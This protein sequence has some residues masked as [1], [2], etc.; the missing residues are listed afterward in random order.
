MPTPPDTNI[1]TRPGALDADSPNARG[2]PASRNQASQVESITRLGRIPNKNHES[3]SIR[4]RES[5]LKRL[6]SRRGRALQLGVVGSGEPL[7]EIRAG[8]EA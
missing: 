1:Y 7:L 6:M 2:I 8:T 4:V 3:G 5:D